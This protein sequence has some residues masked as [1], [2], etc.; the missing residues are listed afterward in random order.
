MIPSTTF[1]YV[2]AGDSGF[3]TDSETEV[4]P[5]KCPVLMLEYV[6]DQGDGDMGGV[7]APSEDVD[8]VM[9]PGEN[10][11]GLVGLDEDV[12]GVVGPNRDVDGVVGPDEHLD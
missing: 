8:G 1:V 5:V 3:E 12:D 10:L 6:H 4:V 11:E 7:V 2:E 9:G